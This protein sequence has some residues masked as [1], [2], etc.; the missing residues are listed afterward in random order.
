MLSILLP[1]NN[2]PTDQQFTASHGDLILDDTPQY[3]SLFDLI[4]DEEIATQAEYSFLDDDK[5][6]FQADPTTENISEVVIDGV[7]YQLGYEPLNP[8]EFTFDP[9]S[10]TVVLYVNQEITDNTIVNYRSPEI[11]EL[12]RSNEICDR[13]IIPLFQKWNI[14]ESDITVGYSFNSEPTLSEIRFV[15]CKEDINL[16]NTQ[17][18]NGTE[19][20]AFN[21]RWVI[22]QLAIVLLKNSNQIGV[23]IS[24]V[25]WLAARGK[26][27]KSPLDTRVR[28]KRNNN[29]GGA[30]LIGIEHIAS[31]SGVNYIGK[32]IPIRVHRSASYNE[33]TSL[34]EALNNYA[35]TAHGFVH[36]GSD[37]VEIRTWASTRIHSI[38]DR[39]VKN[40]IAVTQTGHGSLEDGIKL[41]TEYRNIQVNLDFDP[42]QSDRKI[43][44]TERWAFENCNSLF[45][46]ARPV[47]FEG[48]SYRVPEDEYFRN[49]G[50][51]FDAGGD[52]RKATRIVEFNGTPVFEQQ[53]ER[54][55][56]FTS[57]DS[58]EVR[59]TSEGNIQLKFK[60]SQSPNSYYQEIKRTNTVHLF[61]NDGYKIA[62]IE[63][64]NQIA[65]LQQESE[66]LEAINLRGQAAL[67]T[68][69]VGGITVPNPSLTAQAD[70]YKFVENLPIST[71]TVYDLARHETFFENTVKREDIC[72]PDY[73]PPKFILNKTYGLKTEIIKE[74]PRN[75]EAFTFPQ[76]VTGKYTNRS[77][78]TTIVN[79]HFPYKYETRESN[80]NSEGEYAKNAI[81]T[82]STTQNIGKPGLAPRLDKEINRNP[83]Q[84]NSAFEKYQNSNYFLDSPGVSGVSTNEGSKSYP[85]V[86][87][88]STVRA[89]AETELSII[90]TQNALTTSLDIIYRDGLEV[91]DRILFQGKMWVLFNLEDNR[92]IK[93]GYSSSNN[94]TLRLGRLLKPNVSIS[95]RLECPTA[96]LMTLA[97]TT[98]EASSEEIVVPIPIPNHLYRFEEDLT[99]E[100][101]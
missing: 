79:R 15:A 1:V 49:V 63:R 99:D 57:D 95:N 68:I 10:S 28:L 31:S 24:S 59:I 88:P 74:N 19:F 96:N 37:G 17:L 60:T 93:Q 69:D 67:Q 82:S 22:N 18:C 75:S 39:E 86:D 40:D 91:G 23:N 35:I 45:H 81:H 73:V 53:R 100:P 65:R 30:Q 52:I 72:D 8:G 36:Y 13:T 71:T 62:T 54:G 42:D 34:R 9:D 47:I 41:H 21:N 29:G 78:R 94:M 76:I 90:N 80:S 83:I 5:I 44:V 32:T 61:D 92:R 33:T 87:T 58:Y 2:A 6:T 4:L 38:S 46:L 89:I 51:N 7:V 27:S 64:G 20:A 70:A 26:P 12:L 25:H 14:D 48:G 16:I 97:P 98:I 77:T 50:I 56:A 84:R 43:G 85:D 55:W 101:G 66:R 3:G 11:P